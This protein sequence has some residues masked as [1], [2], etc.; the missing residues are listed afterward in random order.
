VRIAL[1]ASKAR[2]LGAVLRE[3][4]VLALGGVALGLLL[5]KYT[6]GWLAAFSLENDQYDAILFGGMA[7]V[8]FVVTV[9][10]ALV[11]ALRATRVD[12]VEALRS[13]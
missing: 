2:I 9:V 7:I 3:G 10:A 12:P 13:E 4:N 5:V 8:L 11:P 6:A 1:G